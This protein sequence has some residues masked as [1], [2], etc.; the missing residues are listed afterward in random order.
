MGAVVEKGCDTEGLLLDKD[1]RALEPGRMA[2]LVAMVV[3]C[4]GWYYRKEDQDNFQVH[5]SSKVE[6]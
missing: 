1:R 6:M 3:C 2:N 4:D 5:R